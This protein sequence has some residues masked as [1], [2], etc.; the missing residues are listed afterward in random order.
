MKILKNNHL[1]HGDQAPKLQLN[2]PFSKKEKFS[3][4][5]KE[6]IYIYAFK[7]ILFCTSKSNYTEIHTKERK[8]IL[9]SRT[10]KVFEDIFPK[11]SFCRSHQSFLINVN[12]VQAIKPN[13]LILTNK[14]EIPI[15]K[16][17]HASCITQILNRTTNI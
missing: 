5:T 16:S 3:I 2:K 10:L 1:D 15:S 14:Q 9:V 13:Y 7:D 4:S 17:K 11:D 6:G 12:E 8:K